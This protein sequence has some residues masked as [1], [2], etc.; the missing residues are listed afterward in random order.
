MGQCFF[1][2]RRDCVRKK[3]GEKGHLNIACLCVDA[4]HEK[5]RPVFE[6][7]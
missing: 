7:I 2:F 5:K 4:A 6:K 3:S 1:E